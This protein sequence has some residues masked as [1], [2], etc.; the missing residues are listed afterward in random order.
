M[1]FED[2]SGQTLGQYEL[3]EV[4]GRGGMGAVYRAH[5]RALKRDVAIKVLPG[6][7]AAETDYVERFTREAEM[8]ASLEH[9]HIIPVY[10]YGVE[11]GTS[12]IVMRMLTG[13]TLGDRMAHREAEGRPLPSLGEISQLLNQIAGAFDYAH[14]QNVIHRDVKPSNIMFD[15]QGNAFLVDFGIAKLLA[16]TSGLTATGAVLGT[17]LY[18]AP[19]QWRSEQP[20][21][22]TD[23]YALGVTI[24]QLI[25]GRVPFDAPTPF[26]LMHKHLNEQPTA[27]NVMRPDLPEDL[28]LTLAR[29][30]AKNPADRFPTVTAFAHAFDSATTGHTGS[31]TQF[32]VTPV[33][34]RPLPPDTTRERVL[35]SSGG[36]DAG[37][38]GTGTPPPPPPRTPSRPMSDSMTMPPGGPPTV[39]EPYGTS[40]GGRGRFPLVLALIAVLVIAAAVVIGV[41]VLGGSGG[42]KATATPVAVIPSETPTPEET[43]TSAP[44]ATPVVIVVVPTATPTTVAPPP[45]TVPTDTPVPSATSLPSVTPAPSAT[46]EPSATPQPP[47][48]TVPGAPT[49]TE[50]SVLVQPSATPQPSATS[51]P[52]M[53]PLPSATT[54]PSP[55]TEPSATPLPTAT[56][57]PT[58]SP[59]AEATSG[60]TATH[61]IIT[62]VTPPSATPS[63]TPVPPTL[64]ATPSPDYNATV[65]AL[66]VQALTNT[67]E[68]WTDTPVPTATPTDTLTPTATPTLTPSV[69]PSPTATETATATLPPPPT[70]TPTLTP[71]ATFTPTLTPSVT[72]SLTPSVTPSP[73]VFI[74]PTATAFGGGYGQIAFVSE[75]DGNR[76]IY[77]MNVD[78]SG[79]TRLTNNPAKDWD[80]AWSP[81]GSRIAFHSE[82]DGNP[83]IYVMNA[84]GSGQR[85][86]SN[87]AA[88]DYH[89]TWSPDG[90]QIAFY[91]D[92]GGNGDV[93]VMNADGSNVRRLTTTNGNDGG[94]I[95]SP[96]G[97]HLAFNSERDGNSEIYVMNADGSNQ[98][99]LTTDNAND[100]FLSWSS[101]GLQIVFSSMRTGSWDVYIMNVDGSGLRNLTNAGSNNWWPAMSPD[102][103]QIAFISDREGVGAIFLMNSDGS[104]VRAL[105][106]SS[107]WNDSPAWR[108]LP[109]SLPIAPVRYD[110]LQPTVA[111]VAAC[112][113]QFSANVNVRI[114]PGTTYAI[115]GISTVGV[116]LNAIARSPDGFWLEVDYA[117]QQGWVSI[118]LASVQTVGDC[119]S[120]PTVIFSP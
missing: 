41:V 99:R 42:Q 50:G 94:A 83:E 86:L 81:D 40:G 39:R 76:E 64:T 34:R 63:L 114:G 7:L 27:L 31:G 66:A 6:V 24:Y 47:P 73:T 93:Y 112:R 28:N 15:N 14:T 117:G 119:S 12:Y 11:A 79:V 98:T 84:D 1:T 23:Q 88:N 54:A 91:S 60:P 9:P 32:F 89:P 37:T 67:A 30:M 87:N 53:T 92:R 19:E 96:D 38:P 105:T 20:S 77:V 90:T 51:Q 101:N 26:G 106:P 72:P 55:T 29:A 68:A 59:T 4:L 62:I 36:S 3:R 110:L 56:T 57:E 43:A 97:T 115:L 21:A 100:G 58:E 8:A 108:P 18:M 82:R 48:P 61:G 13:G 95:W 10:D 71:T 2:Y 5:Q 49:A 120:L 35:A 70:T 74:L 111:P 78:G 46:L 75:R 116:D 44:T 33:A 69:T 113:V 104:N 17:P 109:G 16:N 52:S 65:E 22:S 80:P 107:S 85:N 45:P 118:G 102:G 103:T 25:T